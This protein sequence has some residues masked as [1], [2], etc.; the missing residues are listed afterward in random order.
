MQRNRENAQ[1]SRQR[2]KQQMEDLQVGC[3]ALARLLRLACSLLHVLV[4]NSRPSRPTRSVCWPL[5]PT[6]CVVRSARYMPSY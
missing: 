6:L 5:A 3:S 2:K 1:L 4:A